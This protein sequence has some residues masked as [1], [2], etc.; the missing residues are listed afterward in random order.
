M[1]ADVIIVTGPPG[2]GKSTTA[3]ALA[4]KYP[5]S[6]HLHTDDFWRYIAAG[7]IAPYLPESDAQNQV[8]MRVISRA[9]YTYAAG[10]FVTVVDGVVGPWMLG[11][12]LDASDNS[13]L[14]PLHY[15]VLRPGREETVRRAIA[16]SEP[17]ALIDPGP[18]DSMWQQFAD[19]GA[20]ESHVIDTTS[21]GPA[22]TL[23]AVTDAVK[24]G[25]YRLSSAPQR[26]EG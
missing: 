17:E 9:A 8:V 24:S 15:V 19:L 1:T 22:D 4:A 12:F 20:L 5:R 11:T 6:V 13:D 2:A 10:G 23:Q 21:H 3:R 25:R 26:A 18:V 7:A 16:R 14:P